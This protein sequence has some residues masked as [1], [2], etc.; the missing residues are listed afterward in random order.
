[1]STCACCGHA[2]NSHQKSGLCSLCEGVLNHVKHLPPKT[3]EHVLARGT[4]A[5]SKDVAEHYGCQHNTHSTSISNAAA[6]VGCSREHLLLVARYGL[7]VDR[8]P[9]PDGFQKPEHETPTYEAPKPKTLERIVIEHPS[10]PVVI[11]HREPEPE[12]IAEE[13]RPVEEATDVKA[14]VL[15]AFGG[16]LASETTDSEALAIVT[17]NAHR[18]AVEDM[19]VDA[20]RGAYDAAEAYQAAFAELAH[21]VLTGE[22][23]P[24]M[25]L[26]RLAYRLGEYKGQVAAL[27]TV[28]G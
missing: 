2:T 18:A 20:K 4:G 28:S 3:R 10:S 7:S 17:L 12:T 11:E 8:L 21:L 13:E 14:E 5:R 22:G 16:G 15:R 27:E 26:V 23:L 24:D 25:T 9:V 1:M 6:A 19:L